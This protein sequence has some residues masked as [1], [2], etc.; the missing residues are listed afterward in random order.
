MKKVE[1]QFPG[2]MYHAGLSPH[3][4]QN[5][6]IKFEVDTNPPAH[7]VS[8][9]ITVNREVAPEALQPSAGNGTVVVDSDDRL[10]GAE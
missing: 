5:F 1:I 10:V 8:E 6:R 4:S 3:Q 2:L 9:R 7:G